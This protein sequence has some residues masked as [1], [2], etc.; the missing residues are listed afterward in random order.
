MR[1]PHK[2]AA[3]ESFPVI[4]AADDLSRSGT[5]SN[6][7]DRMQAHEAVSEPR[8]VSVYV[9]VCVCPRRSAGAQVS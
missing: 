4:G 6:R 8:H 3:D 7:G 2:E 5:E 9:Y 1:S